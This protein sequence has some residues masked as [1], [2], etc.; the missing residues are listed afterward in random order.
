[1]IEKTFK[2]QKHETK[3]RQFIG[4]KRNKEKQELGCKGLVI[5]NKKKETKKSKIGCKDLMNR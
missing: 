2:K 1:M 5:Y 4:R 3:C